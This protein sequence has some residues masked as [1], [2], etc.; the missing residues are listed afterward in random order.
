M[1]CTLGSLLILT[2]IPLIAAHDCFQASLTFKNCIP[3]GEGDPNTDELAVVMNNMVSG[4]CFAEDGTEFWYLQP[5][6]EKCKDKVD[7]IIWEARAKALRVR[8]KCDIGK[9][10]AGPIWKTGWWLSGWSNDGDK[11]CTHH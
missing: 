3:A 6:E 4:L 9:F 5:S 10:I 2:A 8:D 7:G 11:F 1:K